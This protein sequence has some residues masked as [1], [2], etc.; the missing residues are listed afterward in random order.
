MSSVDCIY[1]C[2]YSVPAFSHSL[3]MMKLHMKSVHHV[4][5]EADEVEATPPPP[6]SLKIMEAGLPILQFIRIQSFGDH[7]K[8]L[9]RYLCREDGC[10]AR[11]ERQSV[12]RGG[13][14]K[15]CLT[16]HGKRICLDR[17]T[18]VEDVKRTL[19]QYSC[20]T[21]FKLLGQK[22]SFLNHIRRGNCKP[23]FSPLPFSRTRTSNEDVSESARKMDNPTSVAD[24][25]VLTID[26]EEQ[27]TG[28]P[29]IT[30][31]P[32]SSNGESPAR[33]P[34]YKPVLDLQNPISR[35]MLT[36]DLSDKPTVDF[37]LPIYKKRLVYK[38]W[39]LS[40]FCYQTPETRLYDIS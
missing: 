4:E 24:S 8:V 38:R 7:G 19:Q 6:V 20:L 13:F 3:T 35:E 2:G 11:H 37:H 40:K 28:G 30:D 39:E 9:T 1:Q 18:V 36:E 31:F 15:H 32:V 25:D 27:S 5:D 21:C 26:C 33:E 14:R 23:P 34:F 12:T 22:G 10:R 16:V 17:L 29:P